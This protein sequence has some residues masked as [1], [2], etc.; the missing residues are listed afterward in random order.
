MTKN[1][2]AGVK[3]CRLGEEPT[4]GM[5]IDDG[6]PDVPIR[7]NVTVERCTITIVAYE[8]DCWGGDRVLRVE[9]EFEGKDFSLVA[10]W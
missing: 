10:C 7:V 9:L 5:R 4:E 3:W 1:R 8:C 2:S 6:V